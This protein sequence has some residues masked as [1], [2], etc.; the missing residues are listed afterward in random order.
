MHTPTPGMATRNVRIFH[1]LA[2]EER[3]NDQFNHHFNYCK[4]AANTLD[5][6][7]KFVFLLLP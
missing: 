7:F 3:D 2:G 1:V 4:L 6:M 5:I